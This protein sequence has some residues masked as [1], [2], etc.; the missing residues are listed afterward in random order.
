MCKTII[1]SIQRSFAEFASADADEMDFTVADKSVGK[2]QYRSSEFETE[3]ISEVE[4]VLSFRGFQRVLCD[5]M[6]TFNIKYVRDV[7]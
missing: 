5:S 2:H 4:I 6:Q 1:K 3:R 7:F